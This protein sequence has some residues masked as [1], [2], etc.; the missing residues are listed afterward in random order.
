[1]GQTA[2]NK[3]EIALLTSW[4]DK[5]K[6]VKYLHVRDDNNDFESVNWSDVILIFTVCL[7]QF[8]IF[9]VK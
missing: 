2:V 7:F 4:I 1:M 5:N 9:S 3:N 6:L 8:I